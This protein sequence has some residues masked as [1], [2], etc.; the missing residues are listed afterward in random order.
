VLV[1]TATPVGFVLAFLAV[2]QAR[3]Q[4][5]LWQPISL[6]PLLIILLVT[7]RRRLALVAALS[8]L[9]AVAV[10][11]AAAI[12]PTD[13]AR[14][15]VVLAAVIPQ[16]AQFA[17]WT[18]FY[19]FTGWMCQRNAAEQRLAAHD[20]DE[21]ASRGALLVARARWTRAGLQSCLELLRPIALGHA[22]PDDADV[23]RRCA[24]EEQHLRQLILL[25][26]E[27]LHLGSWLMRLDR[28]ARPRRPA[29]PSNR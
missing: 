6:T 5:Y 26:P 13:P 15:A 19:A 24:E 14:G 16:L 22:D 18:L 25:S 17:A 3:R 27:L 7:A 20:R 29:D 8:A 2:D 12:W 9:V 4:L 11:L 21:R 10:A 1:A 28:G 23:R